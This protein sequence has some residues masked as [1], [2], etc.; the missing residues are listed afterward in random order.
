MSDPLRAADWQRAW[1]VAGA[2]G[3][4]NE[5]QDVLLRCY[6]EPHRAYHTRQHLAECLALLPRLAGAAQRPAEV[7]LALWFHDAI[8]DTARHDNEARC[9]DWARCAAWAF[10]A[11]DGVAQR[12]QALVLATR[13]QALPQTPDERVLVDIDLAILGAA[14]ARFDDYEQQV[15]RE[16]AAVPEAAFRAGRRRILQQFLDRPALYGTPIGRQLFERRAR[17]N[18]QRSLSRLA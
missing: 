4:D 16:Y 6:A 9:A 13:H 8:Y 7:A 14:P 11:D 15:R 10:G 17:A 5:L 18:L 12:L 2:R 3:A 1:A